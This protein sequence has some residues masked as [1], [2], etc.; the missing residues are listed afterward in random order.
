MF[1]ECI[2]EIIEIDES[3]PNSRVSQ[4]VI[5][6]TFIGLF[7]NFKYDISDL[8]QELKK[9]PMVAIIMIIIIWCRIELGNVN[10]RLTPLSDSAFRA[11]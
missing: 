4:E 5:H 10:A 1:G 3:K 8:I 11:I 9:K 7:I 6:S 2:C